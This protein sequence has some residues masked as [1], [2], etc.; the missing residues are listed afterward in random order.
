MS[1][2]YA[3]YIRQNSLTI[4][5]YIKIT[6]NNGKVSKTSTAIKE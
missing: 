6:E 4:Q 2:E 5:E 1:T 3:S